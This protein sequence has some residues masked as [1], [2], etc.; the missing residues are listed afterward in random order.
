M[1]PIANIPEFPVVPQKRQIPLIPAALVRVPPSRY[2]TKAFKVLESAKARSQN[3]LVLPQPSCSSTL[4]AS[5]SSLHTWRWWFLVFLC[6]CRNLSQSAHRLPQL[7][8]CMTALVSPSSWL[9]HVGLGGVGPS[10][11]LHWPKTKQ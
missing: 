8:H 1:F 6:K 2:S 4:M 9:V 7:L 10:A 5:S 3:S 11:L